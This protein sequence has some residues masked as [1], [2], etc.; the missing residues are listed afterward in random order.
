MFAS[1]EDHPPVSP[2]LALQAAHHLPRHASSGSA[3]WRISRRRRWKAMPRRAHGFPPG[4]RSGSP[5]WCGNAAD[6]CISRQRPLGRA[7]SRCS[8]AS[9]CGKPVCTDRVLYRRRSP[10]CLPERALNAWY[11]SGGGARSCLTGRCRV[12]TAA[13]VTSIKEAGYA[14][15]CWFD[16]RLQPL[17]RAGDTT[18]VRAQVAGR[19]VYLEGAD[20]YRGWFQ[21]SLLTAVAWL[22]AARPIRP[23]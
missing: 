1:E 9:E 14:W 12:P 23:C 11:R 7:R 10:S 16:S 2:L 5:A 3:R 6:W 13:G 20:Q 17:C 8:T 15:T 22:G 21:S 18:S 4:A 19:P